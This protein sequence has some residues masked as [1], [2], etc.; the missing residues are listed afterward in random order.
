M[1]FYTNTL[2]VIVSIDRTPNVHPRHG[3]YRLDEEAMEDVRRTAQTRRD[4][5]SRDKRDA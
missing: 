2:H 5:T 1:F 4:E 3:A